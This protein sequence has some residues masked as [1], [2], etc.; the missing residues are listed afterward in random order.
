MTTRILT[1]FKIKIGSLSL[2]PF[3]DG[4]FEIFMDDKRIY[5]KL[6][7]G[8]FPDEDVILKAIESN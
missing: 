3:A 5:S 4:R 1:Q 7:T 6:E 8:Q 2:A